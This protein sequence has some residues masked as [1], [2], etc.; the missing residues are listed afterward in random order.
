[1]GSKKTCHARALAALRARRSGRGPASWSAHR[2]RQENKKIQ[3][4]WNESPDFIWMA[5]VRG[6]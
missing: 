1:M 2:F 5:R 4:S 6:S 3:Q